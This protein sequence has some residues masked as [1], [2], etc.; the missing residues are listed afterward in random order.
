VAIANCEEM[1][2]ESLAH[3]RSQYEVILV[4]L[5]HI[6]NAEAFPS[7]ICESCD[8]VVLY[9]LD[10]FAVLVL[11]EAEWGRWCIFDAVVIIYPLVRKAGRLRDHSTSY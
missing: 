2:V 6:V 11:L 5:I 8:Y 4:F 3:V 9:V 7:R 10:S 1:L